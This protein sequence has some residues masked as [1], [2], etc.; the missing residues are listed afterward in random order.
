MI[1]PSPHSDRLA[2]RRV[3]SSRYRLGVPERPCDEATWAP[4]SEELLVG[5]TRLLG[6][7]E[8]PGG[9]KALLVRSTAD[10]VAASR[11]VQLHPVSFEDDWREYERERI[12]VEAGFGIDAAAAQAMVDALRARVNRLGLGLYLA[13]DE[14]RLVGAVGQ[15]RLLTRP[16]ARLQEVDVFPAWRGQGYGDAVLAA[17]LGLLASEGSTMAVVGAD[18]DDWPLS[19]Y[20]RRAFRDVARVP[21]TR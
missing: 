4:L 13:R 20:R 6:A 14:D 7:D 8:A 18:E 1:R 5:T 2:E 15:L 9:G 19:W 12:A 3:R 17:M 10:P 16:W 21:L 11:A